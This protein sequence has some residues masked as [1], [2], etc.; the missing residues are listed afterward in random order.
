MEIYKTKSSLICIIISVL[1]VVSILSALWLRSLAEERPAKP[2]YPKLE[3][4]ISM[5]N[6]LQ[7][8]KPNENVFYSPKSVYQALLLTYFGAGGKTEKELENVLGLMKWAKNKTDIENAY[9]L[10]KDAQAKPYQNA[11]VEFISVDKLYFSDRVN[12]KD[13]AKNL[14]NEN[15]ERLNF[16]TEP[17]QSVDH[18][19]QFVENITKNNIK[20][21]LQLDADTMNIQVAIINAVY[22][23]GDWVSEFKKSNTYRAK[24]YKH[25]VEETYVDMMHR[26]GH[27]KYGF[28]EHLDTAVLRMPY[29]GENFSMYIFLPDNSRTAIDELLEELT[30][31]ILDDVFNGTVETWETRVS[32]SFPKFSF[33]QT[34]KLEQAVQRMG[35][36]SFSDKT[37]NFS[38]FFESTLSE[39]Y[40]VKMF[41]KAKIEVDESGSTAAAATAMI[42]Y[43]CSMAYRPLT[44]VEFNCDHPFLFVIH[45]EQ[46]DEI[47]F[48]GI[49]RGPN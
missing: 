47:L 24:F 7:K 11:S 16:F 17:A 20:D 35:I 34:S 44:P 42:S 2:Y 6:L 36:Q 29:K 12:I 46:F 19:N 39:G 33:E 27:F 32:V 45:D 31:T 5:L 37:A 48:A 21:I 15:I 10:E 43:P 13:S 18:I 49:Y 8:N 38:G 26:L 41:H 4:A 40:E 23:K 14:L 22:F 1:A 25:G 3:F 30:P 28:I 9:K